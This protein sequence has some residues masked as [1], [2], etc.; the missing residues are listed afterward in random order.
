MKRFCILLC[1]II[2]TSWSHAQ[3]LKFDIQFKG[4][5]IELD[6]EYDFK[7][8]PI[9]FSKCKFYISNIRFIRDEKVVDV[10]NEYFLVDASE[11]STL[12]ISS[13]H[14]SDNYDQIIFSLG[15]DST[16]NV[17]GVFGGDLDPTNGMY[18]T[19][20]SGYINTKIEGISPLCPARKNKF[21]FHLGGYAFPYNAQRE[22]SLPIA[23]RNGQ[24]VIAVA[25]DQFI[26]SINLTKDFQI[27][28]PNKKAMKL[29]DLFSKCF[30]TNE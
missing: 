24:Y 10:I 7:K 19:W 15:V 16:K 23:Y 11:A 1:L 5:S 26:N 12:H 28:S 14:L 21:Q 17:S 13:D 30:A 8:E 18:W 20:Q 29:A 9:T 25:L 6:K 27:M 22:V 3:E 2:L 4:H